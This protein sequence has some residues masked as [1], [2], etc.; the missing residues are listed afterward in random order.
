MAHKLGFIKGGQLARMMIQALPK[1]PNDFELS[2]LDENPNN[3]C[4]TL[5][6][7]VVVG[8]SKNYADVLQFGQSVDTIILEFEH[9][10]IEALKALEKVGKTVIC[11]PAHLEIIQNKGLQK[12]FLVDNDIPTTP[13][14][15]ITGKAVCEG[16]EVVEATPGAFLHLYGKEETRPQR[17]MGHLTVTAETIEAAWEKIRSLESEVVIKSI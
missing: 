1:L 10:A 4:A 9:V 16:A 13:Y 17:K 14:R 15:N 8:E 6:D 11:L 2:V 12:K 7:T 3:A 5:V